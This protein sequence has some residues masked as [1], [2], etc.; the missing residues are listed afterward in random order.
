M[1]TISDEGTTVEQI[2]R[3]HL[4]ENVDIAGGPS[5]ESWR[6][7]QSVLDRAAEA[8]DD[9]AIEL[10]VRTRDERKGE[11]LALEAFLEGQGFDVAELERELDAEDE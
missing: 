1:Q 5:P 7:V 9:L 2:D 11:M 8:H 10:L 4:P 3:S 6:F